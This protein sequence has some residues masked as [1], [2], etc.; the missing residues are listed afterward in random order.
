MVRTW[1]AS[2]DGNA[3]HFFVTTSPM[4]VNR[5]QNFFFAASDYFNLLRMRNRRQHS[6]EV[7][8]DFA[9]LCTGY[10]L[11]RAFTLDCF[12][13]ADSVLAEIDKTGNGCVGADRGNRFV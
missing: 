1:E 5:L 10:Q 13:L 12:N 3:S 2:V 4:I 8:A 7:Y 6:G 11:R 9:A